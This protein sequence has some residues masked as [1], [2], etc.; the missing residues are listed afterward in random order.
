[1]HW[2]KCIANLFPILVL[3]LPFTLGR[4]SHPAPGSEPEFVHMVRDAARE[5]RL[6]MAKIAKLPN[7]RVGQTTKKAM[8]RYGKRPRCTRF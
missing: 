8:S 3:I 5:A 6:S 2:R 4:V 1:M 7:A